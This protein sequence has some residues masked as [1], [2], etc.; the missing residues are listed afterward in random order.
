M[1][2]IPS[3]K[4][5]E[6]K[7]DHKKCR[8][9]VITR[10][11]LMT[12][13]RSFL[14]LLHQYQH[15]KTDKAEGR[16]R[17]CIHSSVQLILILSFFFFQ[18]EYSYLEKFKISDV[19]DRDLDRA[20]CAIIDPPETSYNSAVVPE[21]FQK[22]MR[23]VERAQN[24]RLIDEVSADAQQPQGK[25]KDSELLEGRKAQKESV[26][27]LRHDSTENEFEHSENDNRAIKSL[28]EFN[29]EVKAIAHQ[30]CPRLKMFLNILDTFPDLALG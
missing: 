26:Q 27:V 15:P 18:L 14:V 7:I 17:C 5:E 1:G 28:E 2:V 3:G 16:I 9:I 29:N 20:K 24:R 11:F 6:E 19:K 12:F 23:N 13:L 22:R 8:E 10:N 4:K 21:G 30:S 25:D